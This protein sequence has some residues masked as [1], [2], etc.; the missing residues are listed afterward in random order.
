M[1]EMMHSS[2]G[3]KTKGGVILGHDT[4]IEFDSEETSH[5]ADLAEVWA[6]VYKLPDKLYYNKEDSHSMPWD[7]DME[8]RIGDLVWFNAMESKNAV[9]IVSEDKLYKLLPYQDMYCAKRNSYFINTSMLPSQLNAKEILD[10]WKQSEQLIYAMGN[11]GVEPVIE[12]IK[13]WIIMLNGYVLL[14]PLYLENKS[15]LAVDKQGEID[16]TKGVIRFM[17]QPN[18]EYIRSEY[19]DFLNLNIGDLVLLNPNTPLVLLERKKY[20]ATFLGD[21]LFFVV[22]RRKIAM[23]L[24]KAIS[25]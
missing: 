1:V 4:D 16:P 18:R 11:K 22:Q 25:L 19:T 2:E 12:E 7:C 15:F 24:K 20:L 10:I 23:I 21:E 3:I 14:E 17:G 8:L 5:V 13:P 9:E 6:R